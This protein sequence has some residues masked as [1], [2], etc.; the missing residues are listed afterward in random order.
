MYVIDIIRCE[1]WRVLEKEL[2]YLLDV[3]L[4]LFVF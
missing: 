4:F 3:Y 1:R 2:K